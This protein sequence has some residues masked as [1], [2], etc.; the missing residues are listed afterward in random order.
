M[1]P[2]CYKIATLT[3]NFISYSELLDIRDLCQNKQF[4]GHHQNLNRNTNS[5]RDT[6]EVTWC[7]RLARALSVCAGN[8]VSVH[9]T[10]YHVQTWTKMFTSGKLLKLNEENVI[11][12]GKTKHSHFWA[13]SSLKMETKNLKTISSYFQVAESLLLSST[14]KM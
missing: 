7:T 1:F 3:V 14:A 6:P 4:F 12:G 9:S 11:L 13:I 2:I 8:K 5:T 10:T